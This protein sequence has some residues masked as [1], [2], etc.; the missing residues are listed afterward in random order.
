M[1]GGI[2]ENKNLK[3]MIITMIIIL[4]ILLIIAIIIILYNLSNDE[5]N[6]INEN[7]S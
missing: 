5:I 4:L 2:M 3:Y 6:Y 7:F 1:Y